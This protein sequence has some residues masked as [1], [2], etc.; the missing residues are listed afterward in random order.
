[1]AQRFE[2]GNKPTRCLEAL[3]CHCSAKLVVVVVVVVAVAVVVVAVV[4]VVVVVAVVVVCLFVCLFVCLVGCLVG[5]LA[6]WLAGWL[7]GW[8]G[9]V[10]FGLVW[11]GY[12]VVCLFVCLF[13]CIDLISWV[14]W[15]PSSF[16][17]RV[18]TGFKF[19]LVFLMILAE[20]QSKEM[21]YRELGQVNQVVEE[22]HIVLS[23]NE[24]DIWFL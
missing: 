4:V 24:G 20:W 5:W 8:L 10:W 16:W 23:K 19:Q 3:T 14:R 18:I 1:M 22:S 9:L 17:C 2:C 13:V 12:L 7:V 21:I 15:G 6:G 11:F